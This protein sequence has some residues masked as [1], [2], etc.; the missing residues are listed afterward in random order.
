MLQCGV[1][2]ATGYAGSALV[3]LLA[4]HPKVEITYLASHSYAGK[5]FSDIYPS[6]KGACDLVLQEEDVQE[7]SKLCSVLFL[8]LPHGLASSK[9]TEEILSRCI[10]IDLGADYRLKD[11]SVY[12]S[13]YKTE[14]GSKSLLEQSVYGLCELH[15]DAIV[16]ANLIA[17]P[18]CYTT[19]S[20]LPLA[21]LFAEGL[22]DPPASSSILPVE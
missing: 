11:S 20:I 21:P 1:I 9:V 8:A 13:W 14:H 19:C 22:V 16:N 2:G 10:V 3:S 5:R 18:G 4:A 7:A 17:N 15:R 12:E 6:L